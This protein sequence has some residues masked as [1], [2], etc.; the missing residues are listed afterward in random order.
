MAFSDTASWPAPRT[1]PETRRPPEIWSRLATCLAVWIGSRW[2]TRQMP[3]ASVSDVVAIAAPMSKLFLSLIVQPD[4]TT[5][6]D[7][8]ALDRL[9]RRVR[10]RTSVPAVAQNGSLPNGST[11]STSPEPTPLP[12]L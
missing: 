5:P 11:A 10:D 1:I 3:V 12:T 6:A 9:A 2:A 4:V 8:A 7:A